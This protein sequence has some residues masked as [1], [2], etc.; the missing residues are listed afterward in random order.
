MGRDEDI[1]VL[2]T[3]MFLKL[4]NYSILTICSGRPFP[5][6]NYSVKKK[7]N[8][9]SILKDKIDEL[10]DETPDAY[11]HVSVSDVVRGNAQTKRNKKYSK[12]VVYKDHVINSNLL[13]RVFLS[14]LFSSH[15]FT[16]N[17]FNEVPS[18]H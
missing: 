4:R 6:R 13:L 5:G 16:P 10:I 14:M 17:D 12:C 9:L 1:S 2:F 15:G 8:N 7:Q 18:S 3:K 11:P